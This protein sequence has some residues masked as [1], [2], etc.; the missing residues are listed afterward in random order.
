MPPEEMIA[1]LEAEIAKEAPDP[2]QEQDIETERVIKS[3]NLAENMDEQEL[4]K[5][6]FDLLEKIEQDDNSRQEWKDRN[7]EYL[8]LATQVREQKSFPWV[9]SSNVKYPLLTT[10]AMQFQSRCYKALLNGSRI[11]RTRVIG[12]DKLGLKRDRARRISEHMSYQLLE[13][14]PMWEEH[15][16][17]LCMVV[18]ICGNAF[19]KSYFDGTTIRSELVLP[20]DLIV[21]FY[22]TS[23]EEA[24]RKTHIVPLTMN[25]IISN[26]RS[27]YYAKV[28]L[29][30]LSSPDGEHLQDEEALLEGQGLTLPEDNRDP[31]VPYMGYECHCYLDLDEDDYAEP[32]I[33]TIIK[34]T[35][36]VVRITPRFGVKDVEFNANEEIVRIKATECFTNYRFVP[37]PR[38]GIYGLGFGHIL[39]HINE[40]TNTL[41]NQII[42]AGTMA[43]MPSGWLA[44]GARMAGGVQ[45]F[46]P[47]E[48]KIINTMADDIRKAVIPLPIKEPSAVLF[49]LLSLFISA[50]NELAAV[51]DMMKGESPGQNQPFS[52]TSAMLEQGMAV[53]ST[54][55]KRMH[56]AFKRELSKIYNLNRLYLPAEVYFNIIDR[57]TG[58]NETLQVSKS[59]Y[60]KDTTDVVP[61]SDPEQVTNYQK[62]ADAELLFNLLQT[63]LINP[64]E[65]VKRILEARGIEEVSALLEL[66]PPQ[67]NP[68]FVLKEKELM[69]KEQEIQ[70]VNQIEKFKAE[71][72]A[73]RDQAASVAKLAEA[74][75]AEASLSLEVLKQE[76]TQML[77]EAKLRLEEKKIE[78]DKLKAQ[79]QER[80]A[81]TIKAS[82]IEKK[83][84]EKKAKA[85]DA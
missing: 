77:E 22:A 8:K 84:K 48:W 20:Q 85:K 9:D 10:A 70:I 23:V 51:T 44:R 62:L 26:M 52:T 36:Q 15:M 39:G 41:I 25:D 31:T 38:S 75:M 68:E 1:E 63:G 18:P 72:Q 13:E 80:E 83:S 11:V 4:N 17:V 74:R 58:E 35:R 59:D 46:K 82:D 37:D 24:P 6:A 50:G 53:Y 43:N 67:P 28:D 79:A 12:S 81:N 71:S 56:R 61:N 60:E 32:Y 73:A 57:A 29:E 54:I 66:P 47:G 30:K 16:D 65:T 34:D 69:L 7:Q 21:N 3:V 14:M 55:F 76:F 27:G 2:E 45:A 78:A 49:N 5:I 40:A 42:D 19:K 33:V 64:Q